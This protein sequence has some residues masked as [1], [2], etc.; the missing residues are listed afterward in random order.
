MD[1]RDLGTNVLPDAEVKIFLTA[2]SA[3][4][5]RRRYEELVEKGEACDIHQIEVDIIKRDEQDM[6]RAIAPLKQAEDA[7]YLD[8]SEL[9]I[10]EVVDCILKQCKEK[11]IWKS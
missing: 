4:R 10:N 5:A 6:N 2:S 8:S 3:E 11:R 7:Y 9:T 1:G